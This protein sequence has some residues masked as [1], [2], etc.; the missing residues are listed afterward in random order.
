MARKVGDGK[1]VRVTVPEN[2]VIEQGKFYLL[3]GVLGW[4]VRGVTTGAGETAQVVLVTETLEYETSQITTADAFAAG[5][6]VYWNAGTKKFTTVPGSGQFCGVVTTAKDDN[7]VIWFVFVG[8]ANSPESDVIGELDNLTTAAKGSIVAAI[9]EVKAA[10]D[11]AEESTAIGTLA[12]LTT[13][14]K[15]SVVAAV[16]EV[17]GAVDDVAGDIGDKAN[18]TTTAKGDLV[19]AINEVDAKVAANHA[20]LATA[21]AAAQGADYVQADAQ[22]VATLA[23][24]TKAK[25]NDVIAALK[26]AG[27][28]AADA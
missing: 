25:L 11:A 24:D 3:D 13:T 16:N 14:A 28:M 4:A 22:S 15:G 23:N 5:D 10:A 17:N 12:E 27:L 21:D 6:K 20:A 2:T 26:T 8:M 9:N 1:S 19:A 7:D 18:L